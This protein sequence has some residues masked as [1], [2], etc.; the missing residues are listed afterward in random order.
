MPRQRVYEPTE[1]GLEQRLKEK[2]ERFERLRRERH[3]QGEDG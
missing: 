3:G 2:L 1:E